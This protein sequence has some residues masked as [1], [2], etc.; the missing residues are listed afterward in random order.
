M[1]G[2]T[3]RP[4]YAAMG[5]VLPPTTTPNAII[6][7]WATH[8]IAPTDDVGSATGDIQCHERLGGM[9][10]YYRRAAWATFLLVVLCV[11]VCNV[12]RTPS[13][14]DRFHTRMAPSDPVR[15][16]IGVIAPPRFQLT[17]GLQGSV[18]KELRCRSS[19]LTLRGVTLALTRTQFRAR[20]SETLPI[21]RR[22]LL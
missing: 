20:D 2:I 5:I 6:R 11:T 12:L 16:S 7:G 9:L 1:P 18:V 21:L 17:N 14:H 13:M 19:I 15:R 10:K 3:H 8:V 22:P 4:G